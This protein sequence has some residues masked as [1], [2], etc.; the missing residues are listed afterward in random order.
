MKISPVM[1]ICLIIDLQT[2]ST[3]L[4]SHFSD[5]GMEMKYD[6]FGNVIFPNNIHIFTTETS[7]FSRLVTKSDNVTKSL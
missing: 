6:S 5:I 7:K 3:L 1:R 4:M 2:S